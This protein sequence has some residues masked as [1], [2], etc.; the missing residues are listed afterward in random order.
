M[1]TAVVEERQ[2]LKTLRWWDGFTIALCQ[3]GFLLG[4]LLFA[5][6]S[7]GVAGATLLWG[8]SAFV[9]LLNV[10]VYSELAMM[11][12]GRSGGISLYA[13]EAWRKYTTLVGPIATFGYWI[14]WSVVLSV[15]GLF[16]GQIIQGAWFPHEPIGSPYGS[17]Y[18]STGPVQFGLPQCIAVGLILAV[19]LFNV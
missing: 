10:W 19:W 17:G 12:P 1:A 18:F 16:T 9:S 3:P 6:G 2:L 14:G 15:N 8:I 7:L 11:F 13:N 4:S 5:Y